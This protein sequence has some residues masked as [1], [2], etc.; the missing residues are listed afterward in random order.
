MKNYLIALVSIIVLTTAFISYKNYTKNKHSS[1]SE[2]K[3]ST[4][5]S[6]KSGLC[7]MEDLHPDKYSD[8]SIYQLTSVWKDQNNRAVKLNEF[9][10]KQVI[11]A[12]I[13]TSCPTA[14]PVIVNDMQKLEAA[15]PE[16]ELNNYHFILVSIDSK[17]DTPS[18][19]EKFAEEKNLNQ[20]RWTL[21]TGPVTDIADLAQTIGFRY[22][23]T[24]PGLFIHSSLIT[25]INAKG[26]IKNQS[27]GLNLKTNKYLTIL[28]K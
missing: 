8:N 22:K 7:C 12:M 17:R 19:L 28:S 27:E 2:I 1:V 5:A 14:C 10:G 9:Y 24:Q 18:Q 6:N 23:E 21:L 16:N 11:L 25:L 26:E 3:S 4:D 13:Y 15:I 20:E